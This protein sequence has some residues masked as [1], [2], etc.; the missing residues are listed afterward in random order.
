M[1][2]LSVWNWPNTINIQS[3]L[4][5][6]MIWC[7]CTIASVGTVLN[8]QPCISSCLWVNLTPV[9]SEWWLIRNASPLLDLIQKFV[10]RL[11]LSIAL[12]IWFCSI[13]H[14][15]SG[16]IL[17]L[18]PA[19]ERQRYHVTTTLIGWEQAWNQPRICMQLPADRVIINN[20]N[21]TEIQIN[22]QNISLKKMDL[23]QTSA[24]NVSYLMCQL[25]ETEWRIY[26]SVN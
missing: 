14:K 9:Y 6:L 8:T 23:M 4:W 10:F 2:Y 25:I 12:D 18:R 5:I 11:G 24:Q 17:G 21:F 19:D 22:V 7:R 13:T 15:I 20:I 3:A 1:E 16:L 26:A